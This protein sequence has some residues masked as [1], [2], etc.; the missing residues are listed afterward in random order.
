MGVRGPRFFTFYRGS[1]DAPRHFEI[2]APTGQDRG[3]Y[4]I[5]LLPGR[6]KPD[7]DEEALMSKLRGCSAW[8]IVSITTFHKLEGCREWFAPDAPSEITDE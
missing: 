1:D 4:D 2:R 6:Y 7:F 5:D 3:P 8:R